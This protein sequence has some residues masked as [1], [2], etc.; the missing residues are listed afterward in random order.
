MAPSTEATITP[1]LEF[2]PRINF[3]KWMRA[4]QTFAVKNYREVNRDRGL[5]TALL[6][7][8]QWDLHQLNR[9]P[10]ANPALPD[11]ITPRPNV[12]MPAD[13]PA[14]ATN[15]VVRIYER[16]VSV[17]DAYLEGLTTL[18]DALI[19]SIGPANAL[20]LADPINGMLQVTC[21]DIIAMMTVKHGTPPSL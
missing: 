15:A 8:A 18:S 21:V 7:D 5:L 13:H 6:T 19:A 11:V 4:V 20:L 9:T 16:A 12:A 17:H 3:P 10:N 14:N 2:D 1:T